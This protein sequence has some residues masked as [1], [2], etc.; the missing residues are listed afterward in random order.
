MLLVLD[1]GA[2]S[3]LA[4]R[5]DRAVATLSVLKKKG[6]W[7][8]VVLVEC[9]TGSQRAD[10]TVHRFLNDGCDIRETLT[11]QLARRAGELRTQTRRASKISAVDAVVAASAEPDG[12]V[13]TTDPKDLRA[14][15]EPTRVVVEKV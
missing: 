15:A 14:L 10:A 8:P 9:L 4:E 7:P 1:S 5:N 2:I 13:L 12:I 11:K 6:A 3:R